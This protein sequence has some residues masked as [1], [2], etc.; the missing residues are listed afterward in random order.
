[1]LMFV[2]IGSLAVGISFVQTIAD[3]PFSKYLLGN[4]GVTAFLL[5][6]LI[7]ANL[8]LFAGT[9]A[10]M[11]INALAGIIAIMILKSVSSWVDTKVVTWKYADISNGRLGFTV[12]YRK[13]TMSFSIL[14]DKF[15]SYIGFETV[16]A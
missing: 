12:T 9:V 4:I 10:S 11:V 16:Y 7:L 2:V 15:L 3:M 5:E 14:R 8:L 1:M 6:L 13:A